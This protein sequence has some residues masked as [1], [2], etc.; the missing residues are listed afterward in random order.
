MGKEK[1]V[2]SLYYKRGSVTCLRVDPDQVIED[3]KSGLDWPELAAEYCPRSTSVRDAVEA[4]SIRRVPL[5][6]KACLPYAKPEVV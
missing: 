3:F 2:R 6:N 1:A 5:A 4:Y